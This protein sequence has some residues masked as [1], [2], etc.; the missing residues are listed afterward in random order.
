[1]NRLEENFSAWNEWNCSTLF[2][3]KPVTGKGIADMCNY[4]LINSYLKDVEKDYED[5]VLFVLFKPRDWDVF[6]VLLDGSEGII[7]EYDYAGGYVVVVFGIPKEM[8]IDFDLLQ[9]GKYSLVSEEF[10][11][12]HD[13]YVRIRGKNESTLQYMVFYRDEK[14]LRE[15]E[16]FLDVKFDEGQELWN[17]PGP[18][19]VLNI[20]EIR[21][22]DLV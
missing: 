18:E 4:G 21:K 14:F 7:E 20:N 16:E 22:G 15:F 2:L 9:Q 17:I 11:K 12:K 19:E 10:K 13:F 1:M 3:L 8:K 6:R 5:D